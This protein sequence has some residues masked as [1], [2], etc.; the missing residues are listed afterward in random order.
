M[1]AVRPEWVRLGSGE[2]GTVAAVRYRGPHTELTIGTADG[3][4]EARVPGPP[5]HR[6]GDAV[7]WEATREWVLGE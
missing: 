3:L 7:R 1:V 5:G 2:P 4:V 6:I